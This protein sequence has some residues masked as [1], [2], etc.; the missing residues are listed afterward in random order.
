MLQYGPQLGRPREGSTIP[1][2]VPLLSV[3]ILED[4]QCMVCIYTVCVGKYQYQLNITQ[5]SHSAIGTSPPGPFCRAEDTW[6]LAF[7]E[8]RLCGSLKANYR[9]RPTVGGGGNVP[10]FPKGRSDLVY[11]IYFNA[12]A[13]LDRKEEL[14]FEKGERG[15]S[16]CPAGLAGEPG[17]GVPLWSRGRP[18]NYITLSS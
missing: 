11:S 8:R 14:T 6:P 2:L 9:E 10:L 18:L 1:D 3:S 13:H 4:Q 5:V 15:G 16:V 17:M 7:L 12:V